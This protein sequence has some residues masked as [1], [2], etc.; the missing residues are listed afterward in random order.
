MVRREPARDLLVGGRIA[1]CFVEFS[2]ADRR[3]DRVPVDVRL[4][5]R[6]ADFRDEREPAAMPIHGLLVVARGERSQPMHVVAVG[7][8][9]RVAE[10]FRDFVRLFC[11]LEGLVVVGVA[12]GDQRLRPRRTLGARELE[13]PPDPVL[14]DVRLR[15]G[16]PHSRAN[17]SSGTRSRHRDPPW[18]RRRSRARSPAASPTRIRRG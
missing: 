15:R 18:S 1:A 9:D 16:S 12:A 13:R 7:A 6:V 14:D 8:D 3:G 17:Q 11:E 2:A 10:A 5:I 4:M